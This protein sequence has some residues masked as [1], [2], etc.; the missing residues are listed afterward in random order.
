MVLCAAAL[1]FARAQAPPCGVA[2]IRTE[3]SKV[4]DRFIPSSPAHVRAAVLKALPVLAAKLHKEEGGEIEA[5]TDQELFA[6]LQRKNR[7][8]DVGGWLHRGLGTF[9]TFKIR[10]Q[11]DNR[12]GQQGSALHIEFHRNAFRGRLGNELYATPLADEV[13]CLCKVLSPDDP[14]QNPRGSGGPQPVA[15]PAT[16]S[17][18][19]A[20]P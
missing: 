19:K 10:I 16:S 20:L 2:N 17:L 9:G 1:G 14:E 15:L 12:D 8:S 6:M 11:P 4:E 7:D 13:Q 18:R 3:G 5:K